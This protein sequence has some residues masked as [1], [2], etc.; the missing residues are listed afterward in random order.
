MQEHWVGQKLSPVSL[1][2]LIIFFVERINPTEIPLR[3]HTFKSQLVFGGVGLSCGGLHH[4][5]GAPPSPEHGGLPL[6]PRHGF[7]TEGGPP[8]RPP[9]PR[10]HPRPPPIYRQASKTTLEWM[11]RPRAGNA[12][13]R[14]D[15]PE[16]RCRRVDTY[17]AVGC[18]KGDPRENFIHGISTVPMPQREICY[19]S[20]VRWTLGPKSRASPRGLSLPPTVCGR[21]CSVPHGFESSHRMIH[22][23]RSLEF[24]LPGNW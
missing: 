3:G 23:I 19:T 2:I 22:P 4:R 7:H 15:D 12:N 11:L 14:F 18:N 1:V 24:S 20:F 5:R 13:M 16:Q 10:T 6:A 9:R 17:P 21:Y 8:P